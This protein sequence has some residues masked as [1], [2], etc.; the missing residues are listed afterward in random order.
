MNSNIKKTFK[1]LLD[2]NNTSSYDGGQF[3]ALYYIDLTYTI[4]IIYH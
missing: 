3:N 4:N 1:I 2:S